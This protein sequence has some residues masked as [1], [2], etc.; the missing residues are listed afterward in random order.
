MFGYLAAM[1]TELIQFKFLRSFHLIFGRDI[2]S[3]F[4]NS[5]G[6]SDCY[7]MFTFFGH[8]ISRQNYVFSRRA[9]EVNSI[10]DF[11]GTALLFSSIS[12]EQ[13]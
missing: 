6:K 7:A 2:V 13:T 5:A 4:A 1:L 3:V 8:I 9:M 11:I 12:K 10:S